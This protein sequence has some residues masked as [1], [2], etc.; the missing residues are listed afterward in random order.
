MERDYVT[1]TDQQL[2]S[3][4]RAGDSGAFKL[5]YDRFW[6]KLLVVAAK[7][8]DNVPEAEEAVQD[9]FLNLWRRHETFELKVSFE[10]YLAVAVKFEVINRR[11]KRVREEVLHEELKSL[12]PAACTHKASFDL[13]YLQQ[14][15]EHSLNSLPPKCQLVFRL[16]REDDYTNKQIAKELGITEK[17]VEK[18]ISK[19]LKVLRRRMGRY[20]RWYRILQKENFT[21]KVGYDA[22]SLAI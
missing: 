2:A 3:L 4:L 20:Y 7:R 15:V 14:Q 18:H 10:N 11:A 19:A 9:I 6:D 12:L 8:L 5:I 16:S 1:L 13:E 21:K 17:A 22:S